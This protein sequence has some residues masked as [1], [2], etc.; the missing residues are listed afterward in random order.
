MVGGLDPILS[1]S[2]VL[3]IVTVLVAGWKNIKRF[4]ANMYK[5]IKKEKKKEKFFFYSIFGFKFVTIILNYA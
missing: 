2:Q 4:I 3:I 5:E 1:F